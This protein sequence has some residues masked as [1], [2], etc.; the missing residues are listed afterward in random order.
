ME[1]LFFRD[2][3]RPIDYVLVYRDGEDEEHRRRR[4]TYEK[5]LVSEGLQLEKE[6]KSVGV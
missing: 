3:A 2:N 6:D 4:K 5:N 1:T